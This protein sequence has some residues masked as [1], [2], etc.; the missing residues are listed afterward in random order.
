MPV[1]TGR[2][3]GLRSAIVPH[4]VVSL[5]SVVHKDGAFDVGDVDEGVLYKLIFKLK[6][7]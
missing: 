4:D 6:N 5:L 1:V 2:D 7:A 3:L